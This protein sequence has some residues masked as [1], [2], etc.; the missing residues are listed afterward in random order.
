VFAT[1]R[2]VFKNNYNKYIDYYKEDFIVAGNP[3]Q[4]IKVEKNDNWL[5]KAKYT[6]ID[7]S[8]EE[9]VYTYELKLKGVVSSC[10]DSFSKQKVY[11]GRVPLW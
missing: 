11:I 8:N 2:V 7:E 5:D 4:K 1:R 10:N 6:Y 3:K 9:N